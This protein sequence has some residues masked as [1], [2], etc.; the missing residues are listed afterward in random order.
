[1]DGCTKILTQDSIIEG[2]K[3]WQDHEDKVV[4]ETASRKKVKE[5]YNAAM[6]VWKVWELDRK[7]WNVQIKGGW[8]DE[9]RR[10]GV[11]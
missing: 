3:E 8:K 9:V 1:M 7:E 2:V 5:Q 10:W 6:N 11:E 4:E